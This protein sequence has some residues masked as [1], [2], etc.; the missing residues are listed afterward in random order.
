MDSALPRHESAS[1]EGRADTAT[2]KPKADASSPSGGVTLGLKA[3]SKAQL[4]T[5]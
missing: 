1:G 2:G 5:Q 3:V 4:S